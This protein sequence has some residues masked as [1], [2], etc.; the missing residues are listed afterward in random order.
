MKKIVLCKVFIL[1]M[2]LVSLN[3]LH[4]Q[5]LLREV[6][7]KK[8]IENSSLVVE[9]KVVSKKSFW[10][11]NNQH[12]YTANTIEVYKVFKGEPVAVIEV[13]TPGGTV[14]LSAEMVS[15]SLKL[16][17]DEV[18]VFTLYNNNIAMKSYEKTSLKQ[19]QAYGS[20]QGFYKYNLYDNLAVNTF[21]KKNGIASNFYDEIMGYTKFT[22]IEMSNFDTQSIYLKSTQGKELLAPGSITFTPTTITAG[23]KSVLTIN[24]TGFGAT[25]GKVSFRNA[26]DGGATFIDAFNTQILEWGNTQIKVEVPSK[27]GTGAIVVTDASSAS[28]QSSNSLTILF[29]EINVV[30]DEG[31]VAY[32]AQHVNDNNAGGYTWQMFTDFN[33]NANAK[34]A[35]LRAFNSWRCTTGINWVIGASTTNDVADLDGINVVRFDNG[36]ELGPTELG[37]CTTYFNGCGTGTNLNWYVS[38]LDIVFDDTTDWN[39]G[40]AGT[41]AVI[42]K[43]DFE[44]NALHELGHGHALGHVISDNDI[45][46]YALQTAIDRRV[47]NANNIA[48]ANAIQ[49]RS[50]SSIVCLRPLLTNHSCS[51]GVEEEALNNSITIY[52]N[53][54]NGQFFIKNNLSVNLDKILIH[55]V[56]GRLISEL[57]TSNGTQT[58]TINLSGVSKGLYFMRI[59]SG[60]TEIT[61]KILVE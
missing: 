43:Y 48:A 33:N 3:N 34:A 32:R 20:S 2:Y 51:L 35:F 36:A 49:S 11:A 4:A 38:E 52:P 58:I 1:L 8:Q 9:G 44:S 60:T 30:Q 18:G 29:S 17:N 61:K 13:I 31:N 47:L 27:A 37:R 46:N 56:S 59:L 5:T 54:T 28:K 10:D 24:G 7:L 25:K 15:P 41:P 14:G 6:S 21:N 55:D 26:D 16:N 53:P 45:M 12:I 23:T 50:I 42:G 39:F 22:Y 57:D 40:P 19:F